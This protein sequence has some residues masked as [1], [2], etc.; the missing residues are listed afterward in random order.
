MC[1]CVSFL[2]KKFGISS[3]ATLETGGRSGFEA[4]GFKLTVPAAIVAE[5][6]GRRGEKVPKKKSIPVGSCFYPLAIILRR[7]LCF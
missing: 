1:V 4:S 3:L 2:A 7:K 5:K 6:G